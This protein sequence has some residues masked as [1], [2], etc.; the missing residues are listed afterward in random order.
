M[1]A[2][3]SSGPASG[4]A[5]ATFSDRPG[6]R[7]RPAARRA[8]APAAP[9]PSGGPRT[10]VRDT[11]TPIA[12]T[13]SP[14]GAGDRRGHPGHLGLVLLDLDRGAVGA[15]PHQLPVQRPPVGHRARRQPGQPGP[16]QQLG[17]PAGPQRG[18]HHLAGRDGVRRGGLADP[19]RV[20]PRVLEA[21]VDVR[22]RDVHVAR[23]DQVGGGPAGGVH[24]VQDRRARRRPA[25]SA[26][27]GRAAARPPGSPARSRARRA[28]GPGSPPSTRIAQRPVD[29]GQRAAQPAGDRLGGDPVTR[30]PRP[31][32]PRAARARSR[33]RSRVRASTAPSVE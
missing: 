2:E 9:A 5:A 28:A 23:H 25:G 14:S 27:P 19:H 17:Q 3:P 15:D 22:H 30:P 7:P 31:P 6:P 12:P 16:G 11:L 29:G 10:P 13:I 33:I 4:C 8:R 24:L 20:R 21:V 18:Q 1:P 26:R 32:R